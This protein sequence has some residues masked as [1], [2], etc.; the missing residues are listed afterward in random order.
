MNTCTFAIYTVEIVTLC[1]QEL[2]IQQVK[3]KEK[4]VKQTFNALL[5]KKKKKSCYKCSNMQCIATHFH[6]DRLQLHWKSLKSPLN[7]CLISRTSLVWAPVEW[8]WGCY[9]EIIPFIVPF[10]SSYRRAG[11][12]NRQARQNS[13]E[14]WTC[15]RLCWT[16][17]LAGTCGERHSWTGGRLDGRGWRGKG[18]EGLAVHAWLLAPVPLTRQLN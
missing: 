8:I 6:H 7:D 12:I 10:P 17:D 14:E 1:E 11:G 2:Q 4:L 16:S 3:G 18:G 13:G 15:C 9:T 5:F